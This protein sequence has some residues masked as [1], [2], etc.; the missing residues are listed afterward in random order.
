MRSFRGDPTRAAG[1]MRFGQDFSSRQRHG[2]KRMG[3]YTGPKARIN[4]RLG[5]NVYDSKGAERAA[6]RRYTPPGQ[7]GTQRRRRVSD[8]GR[9]L[10]E[11]QKVRHYYGLSQKQLNR[12]YGMAKR[13]KGNTGENLLLI[14]E[15]RLDNVVW[16]AGLAR[17]RSQARQCCSHGHL[18]VNGR[19]TSVPSYLVRPEDVI[20]VR[21]KA[22][23]Q[24]MYTQVTEEVDRPAAGFL[25]FEPKELKIKVMRDPAPDDVGLPVN[26]NQVVEFL[27]R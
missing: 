15:R 11:K 27:A 10:I 8:Y 18:L 6:N 14:C 16:K 22:N 20:E 25:A 26:I 7:Q 24:K 9:A 5:E 19:R 12:F 17:S 23:L 13:T 3:H 21:K 1:G 4:R 2:K